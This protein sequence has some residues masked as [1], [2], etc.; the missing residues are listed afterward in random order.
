MY[1][2]RVPRCCWLGIYLLILLRFPLWANALSARL[3][4]AMVSIGMNIAH[5]AS[6]GYR[7]IRASTG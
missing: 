7:I 2:R 5:D 4:F 6:H 1:V 3:A